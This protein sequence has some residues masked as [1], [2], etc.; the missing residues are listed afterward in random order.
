LKPLDCGSVTFSASLVEQKVEL[1]IALR[2]AG[3]QRSGMVRDETRFVSEHDDALG[4]DFRQIVRANDALSF[5]IVELQ[6]DGGH[7]TE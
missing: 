2:I 1:I 6:V 5:D 7:I 3:F 4:L